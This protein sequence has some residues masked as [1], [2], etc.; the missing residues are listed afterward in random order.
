M[1]SQP[2]PRRSSPFS[3]LGS[4]HVAT[5]TVILLAYL[6]AYIEYVVEAN[7]P[8]G[9]DYPLSNLLLGTLLG[10]VYLFLLV[11]DGF[12]L[13]NVL[14][15]YAK[16]VQFTILTALMVAIQFLM[17]GTNGIWL[18]SMPLVALATT[19][20]GAVARWLV[21]LA[22]LISLAGPFY[23]VTGDPQAALAATLT[24]SPAI[25]FVAVFARLTERAEQAQAEAEALSHEL[26][27]ANQQLSAY[28][29]Q[30]EELAATQ[31]RN[32]LAREIHD[33]LGH[34]LTVVNVQI[35]AALAV[36]DSDSAAARA[37]LEKARQQTEDGLSAIRQS[38]SA[39]RDSPLGSQTL[40]DAVAELVDDA[41]SAGLLVDYRVEGTPRRL[42]PT[43]E[44]TLFRGTQEALTNV[45]RHAAASRVDILLDYS[46]PAAVHLSVIDNGVGVDMAQHKVGFGLLGLRERVHQLDGELSFG[47]QVGE[48]FAIV[49]T[50]P[51]V[52]PPEASP[53]A[54]A[55]LERSRG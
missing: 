54:P 25:V 31:E 9:A 53:A 23:L 3:I 22:A 47:G 20:L 55:T 12:L 24:F 17:A 27:Q 1:S 36:M 50:L 5:V 11:Q 6:L 52:A 16:P 8:G 33:N 34:Y 13:D 26:E 2:A 14:P 39:L 38:V 19:E 37:T 49:V 43:Q 44:L 45:R 18:V 29:V 28:A 15:N 51:T 21:Y 32:R 30:A 48:G 10:V 42:S 35:K 40:S 7:S 46:D 4:P 41:Q